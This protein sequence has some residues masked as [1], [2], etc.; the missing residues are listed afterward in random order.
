M[1]SAAPA[2]KLSSE[3]KV[4]CFDHDPAVDTAIMT[5][6]DGGTTLKVQDMRDCDSLMVLV[7]STVITDDGVTLLEIVAATD[8]AMTTP[9]VIKAHAATVN[10][11]PADYSILEC[12]DSDL[13]AAATAGLRYAA[14]RIT[15]GDALDEARVIYIAKLKRP[16]LDSTASVQA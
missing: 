10:D 15:M 4:Q 13:Q 5:S 2:H 6:A 11:A 14:A 7:T 8:A 16:A 3:L 12:S 1:V 9:I